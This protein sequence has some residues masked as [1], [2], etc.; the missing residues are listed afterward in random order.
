MTAESSAS[1]KGEHNADGTEDSSTQETI[2]TLAPTVVLSTNTIAMYLSTYL[3]CLKCVSMGW[4]TT[5]SLEN[6]KNKRRN[7]GK[8]DKQT[9][10]PNDR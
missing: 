10:T 6:D 9:V 3:I 1:T 8:K 7:G 5:I 4:I 2:V